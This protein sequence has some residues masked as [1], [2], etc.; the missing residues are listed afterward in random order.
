MATLRSPRSIGYQK[1]ENEQVTDLI[2]VTG[3]RFLFGAYHF[4]E[5]WD[6]VVVVKEPAD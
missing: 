5:H 3:A 6:R 2:R 4:L 1:L